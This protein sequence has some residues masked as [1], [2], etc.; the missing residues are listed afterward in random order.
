MTRLRL[1]LYLLAVLLVA[2]LGWTLRARAA[3]LLPVDYDED[4]YLLAAQ[5]FTRLIRTSD[6]RGF[7]DTNYRDVHPPL[8]KIVYGLSL[9]STPQEPLIPETSTTSPPNQSLS[10]FL[11]Y[12][13]RT[14][15]VVM[16]ALEVFLLALVNP[17]GGL[18]LASHA[19]TI[20]YTSQVMLES[21]P[22]LTSLLCALAYTQFKKRR[23]AGWW[24]L[25]ALFLGLTAASKYLYAV[26]GFAVLADWLF[27][28]LRNT[29]GAIRSAPRKSITNYQSL[30][31]P[32]L[33]GLLSLL[34]FLA[35]DPYLWPDPFGRLQESLFANTSY[36]ATASEIQNAGFPFWQPINWL[37]FS[38]GQWHP[39]VFQFVLD[40]LIS[41]LALLGLARLWKR[42]RVYVL[43]LGIGMAFLLVWPTKWPQYIVMLS[44]P[45][46]LAAAEGIGGIVQSLREWIGERRNRS[47]DPLARYFERKDARR[48][49]PWLAPGLV[50]LAILTVIPIL[51]QFAM[52]LTD[53][54]GGSIRDGLT[55]GVW[56]AIWLGLTGQAAPVQFDPFGYGGYFATTVNYA[57][58]GLLFNLLS[59]GSDVLVFDVLWT[60]LSV[61]SQA[62]LGV[63]AALLL[64]RRGLRW[65]NL[66]RTLFILPWAVPEFVGA[67]IWLRSFEPKVGWVTMAIPEGA[68]FPETLSNNGF[69]L[70]VLL[71]AAA[72]YGFPFVMLAA[73]ASLKLVPREVYDAAAM[74]GASGWTLFREVTWPLLLPLVAP[75]LILRAIYSF[76]QFYLFYVMRPDY[77]MTTLS[78]ESYYAMS[79]GNQYAVSAA[80]NVISILVLVGFLLWF[81][82]WSNASSGVTYA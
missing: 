45:L 2:A 15:A 61:L 25:S 20:K 71:V 49:L 51:F 23:A 4:D 7:L 6:W 14:T 12:P 64:E 26:V 77:P 18:F 37:F 46:S 3:A 81:N 36:S 19:L 32:L 43:W 54:N 24:I 69:G 21:L 63:G 17:L 27:F 50:G 30:L 65:A 70:M 73:S 80:I 5:Q 75:A 34:F 53:F 79:Y 62:V 68:R 38:V 16:G 33:W 22:A 42:E 48:A 57:G 11:L 56:R 35:A 13:A 78:T 76:N 60:V 66:W 8:A 40:P 67:L 72:W 55:G 10:K 58:P 9:L 52:S 1:P 82:R 74:D 44:A 28:E 41:L 31:T 29:Q 59:G 47:V 39:D